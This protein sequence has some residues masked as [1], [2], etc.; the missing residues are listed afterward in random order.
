MSSISS[1]YSGSGMININTG[2]ALVTNRVTAPPSYNEEQIEQVSHQATTCINYNN[3]TILRY[4]RQGSVIV[5]FEVRHNC[6]LQR[7]WI[8]ANSIDPFHVI[9]YFLSLHLIWMTQFR[10][11]CEWQN[12]IMQYLDTTVQRMGPNSRIGFSLYPYVDFQVQVPIES[13]TRQFFAPGHDFGN[14]A[15]TRAQTPVPPPASESA[16][17]HE[18]APK[19]SKL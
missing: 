14:N 15:S 16:N 5:Q 6:N 7:R 12:L 10:E 13:L 18:S 19:R 9:L 1:A 17:S 4:M 8:S 11:A 2:T 3:F